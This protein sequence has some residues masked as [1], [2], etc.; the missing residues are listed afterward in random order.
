MDRVG[1][2][3]G[4]RGNSLFQFLKLSRNR[5]WLG[6]AFI[7]KRN[8]GLILVLVNYFGVVLVPVL[9]QSFNFHHFRVSVP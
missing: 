5:F 3:L 7:Y 2:F 9:E 1:P 8:R 4:S 6:F